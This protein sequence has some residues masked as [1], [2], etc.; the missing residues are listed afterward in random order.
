MRWLRAPRCRVGE[1]AGDGFEFRTET[2][3]HM[4]DALRMS[5]GR[6]RFSTGAVAMND[7]SLE[8]FGERVV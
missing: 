5:A 8:R 4:Q 2:D 6:A 3:A 7:C 1:L